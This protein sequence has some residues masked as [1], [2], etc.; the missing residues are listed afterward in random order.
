MEKQTGSGRN[1]SHHIGQKFGKK[2]G[3]EI[4]RKG[5]AIG[6]KFDEHVDQIAEK[7][8]TV[9]AT[10]KQTATETAKTSL[11][12]V[13]LNLEHRGLNIKDKQEVILRVGQTV[14]DRA[15]KIRAQLTENSPLGAFA[16]AWMKEPLVKV[17]VDSATATSEASGSM[18]EATVSEPAQA[19]QANTLQDE[20]A[21]DAA[22]V[23]ESSEEAAAA[24]KKK[25]SKT[26]GK[27]KSASK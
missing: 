9:A 12:Q 27:S 13:L 24:P 1:F 10:V 6:Q 2:L 14:L 7:V 4:G 21:A 17:D 11:D 16:P 3:R 26:S 25:S 18:T 20:N 5:E 15:E 19:M 22:S 23:E 8:T